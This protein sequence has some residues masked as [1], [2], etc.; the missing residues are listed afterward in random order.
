MFVATRTFLIFLAETVG[1]EPLG[2]K[3]TIRRKILDAYQNAYTVASLPPDVN[4]A[5]RLAEP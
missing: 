1:F 4:L 2:F 3:G 5:I